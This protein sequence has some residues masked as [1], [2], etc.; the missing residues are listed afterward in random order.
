MNSS[1]MRSFFLYLAIAFSLPARAQEGQT[2]LPSDTWPQLKTLTGIKVANKPTDIV[3]LIVL[4]DANCPHCAEL[5]SHLYGKESRYQQVVSLWAPV[6][7]VNKDSLGKAASLLNANS[8]QALANNFENF[9][10]SRRSGAA[11]S[12]EITSSMRRSLDRNTSTWKKIMSATPLLIYKTRDGQ[13]LVQVGLAP[14][15]RLDELLEKLA[16]GALQNFTQ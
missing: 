13:V 3:Q 16:P 15:I 6:A 1:F 9:D 8:S 5:W 2:S 10:Y 12:V 4:F 14:K 11:K 7:Y